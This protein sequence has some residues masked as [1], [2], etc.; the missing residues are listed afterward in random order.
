M[1]L[2]DHN[3]NKCVLYMEDGSIYEIDQVQAYQIDANEKSDKENEIIDFKIIGGRLKE[4]RHI[5]INHKNR[6]LI[7]DISFRSSPP[8]EQRLPCG[9]CKKTDRLCTF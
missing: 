7:E 5:N 2:I 9:L 3:L 4:A 1:S 8:C 6:L